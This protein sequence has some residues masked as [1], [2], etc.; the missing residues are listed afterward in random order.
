MKGRSRIPQ[1]VRETLTENQFV[2]GEILVPRLL[3]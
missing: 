3:F 2:D 1:R